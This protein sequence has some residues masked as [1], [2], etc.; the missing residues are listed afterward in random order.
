MTRTGVSGTA[1]LRY[2]LLTSA[3]V[4]AVC[5]V[6]AVVAGTAFASAARELD[7]VT[8]RTFGELEQ[9][10]GVVLLR[11]TPAGGGE[12]LDPVEL[13][14][15]PPPS[16]TVAEVAYDPAAPQRP[17]VPGAALLARADAALG[18]IYLTATVALLVVSTSAW[19]LVSR[20]RATARPARTLA[21]R[22]VRIQNG[23]LGRS[24]LETENE[25]HRW[26]PVHFD[27]VLVTL[28][29]PTYVRVHG[30][31]LA[32]RLVAVE[33]EG[34]LLHPSG[35]VRAS[36]PRGHRRDNPAQPDA[37]SVE[38]SARIAPLRPRLQADLPLVL[39]APV[40]AAL[41]AYVDGGGLTTWAGATALLAA[42]TLWV[43]ALRGSDPS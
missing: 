32:D 2:G 15:T 38:R 33:V 16:G 30:D 26:I 11:W 12:R 7:A 23:M 18:T 36:E 10:A 31:P 22:R 24:W 14:G 29:S 34:R 13:T 43:G 20:R 8:A 1:A 5:A 19:Q 37:A 25:P 4:L 42:A 39:A 41:W 6:L 21:V 27:P 3:L 17:L 35:P 9:R 40:V 28:P